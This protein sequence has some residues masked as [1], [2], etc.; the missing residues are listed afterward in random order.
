[1]VKYIPL[2]TNMNSDEE[3]DIQE[4]LNVLI[5]FIITSE[6]DKAGKLD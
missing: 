4:S 5:R 1:M 2:R 3:D 6:P